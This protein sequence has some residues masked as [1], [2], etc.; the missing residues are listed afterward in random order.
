LV[1]LALA[2]TDLKIPLQVPFDGQA[3]TGY[4]AS[5]IEGLTVEKK[6]GFLDRGF[7]NLLAELGYSGQ[8]GSGRMMEFSEARP[9]DVPEVL[10]GIP[11]DD[12]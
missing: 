3:A 10:L 4:S 5:H 9:D 6:L 1:L 7:I 2:V 12:P 8:D 11:G